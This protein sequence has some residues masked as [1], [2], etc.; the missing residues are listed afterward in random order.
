MTARAR[1]EDGLT[2]EDRARLR[3][4]LLEVAPWLGADALGPQAVDAGTCDA[5]AGAPR[6]LPTCG[7]AGHDALCPSCALACGLDAWCDGHADEG[8]AALAW[9][10]ALPDR[11][12]DL[13]VLWWVATGE[14]RPDATSM[15][16]LAALPATVSAALS[17][18][19][20][21]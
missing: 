15:P 20:G 9:A 13:V 2:A 6:I 18:P 19:R 14:V 4:A 1:S 11:W 5:C 8:R 12:S 7:P 16:D 21:R 3:T 17:P 10:A